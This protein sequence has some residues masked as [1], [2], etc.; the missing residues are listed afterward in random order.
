MKKLTI[1][2][3]L[4]ISN[5]CFSQ[6]LQ[7]TFDSEE[8]I[9]KNISLSESGNY[10]LI[11]SKN[12]IQLYK[13]FSKPVTYEPGSGSKLVDK[14]FFDFSWQTKMDWEL[15]HSIPI[16]TMNI[17]DIHLDELNK[18]IYI[19]DIGD[20]MVTKPPGKI[21]TY[22]Y[23][24]TE[25]NQTNTLEITHNST[26]GA[27]G[28]SFDL[29]KNNTYM[30]VNMSYSGKISLFKSN[31]NNWELIHEISKEEGFEFK[32]THIDINYEGSIF[33]VSKTNME[34]EV[35]YL[36]LYTIS[37]ETA[38]FSQ[39]LTD[40][41]PKT[42]YGL[43]YDFS[44]NGK[45]LSVGAREYLS[46]T[47]KTG[48]VY[49]YQFDDTQSKWIQRGDVLEGNDT[50]DQFGMNLKISGDGNKLFVTGTN[51]IYGAR[52][53][54]NV[55]EHTI[56]SFGES[57]WN[58]ISNMIMQSGYNGGYF[59]HQ[60][61]INNDGNIGAFSTKRN[62][63]SPPFLGSTDI[64]TFDNVEDFES[65]END[66]QLSESDNFENILY[67][68][69][70]INGEK[71]DYYDPY[72]N[73]KIVLSFTLDEKINNDKRY[74]WRI[75][76][77]NKESWSESN[78]FSL[79][80]IPPIVSLV[81]PIDGSK[82]VNGSNLTWDDIDEKSF[83][84]VQISRFNDFSDILI[85]DT[86]V[87][88]SYSI[89]SLNPNS[90]FWRIRSDFDGVKGEWSTIGYFLLMTDTDGDGIMDDV[91]IC[92]NT[93]TGET[94]DNN[95]CSDSQKDTDGD[96]IMDDVDI[97]PNTPTGETVD[98]DGCSDSQK[99][100]DGDGIMDDVDI[101]PNTPTGE[102]VDNNG[103]FYLPLDNFNIQVI[104][105]TCPDKKNGQII[106][107]PSNKN[108]N[109]TVSIDGNQYNFN[110]TETVLNLLPGT[111]DFCVSITGIDSFQ[112][113]Y[114][115]NI[116]EGVKISGKS[117][118]TSNKTSIEITQG[119]SPYSIFIN[120]KEQ[121]KTSSP[122][123]LVET[124]SGDLI[125]VK[126]SIE[127]EGVFSKSIDL[128]DK[129]IVYPNPTNGDFKI[130]LPVSQKEVSIELYTINSKL[131]SVKTYP[132]IYGE[133]QLSIEDK[134]LGIYIIKVLLDTP[135]YLKII[136]N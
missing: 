16:N 80:V 110:D 52:G 46:E 7:Y 135:V 94:V 50:Y 89:N 107:S 42:E 27:V 112:Q 56:S 133:I 12:S 26:L 14:L 47:R 136:K 44:D 32:N 54:V 8:S 1:F 132:V 61:D 18:T 37:N 129:M 68:K 55:Y 119:T 123:F 78:S 114:S 24:D 64:Y 90:Y 131:I 71:D 22:T 20:W 79:Y 87:S 67:Q 51:Q 82:I 28:L 30:I 3:F 111:Y 59:G 35:S 36:D 4:L 98:T 95:G 29:S 15:I 70:N 101:C 88:N 100:T 117:S 21:H 92:P 120:G 60:M 93:P 74:F 102:T 127:C 83:Y 11:Q 69:L 134:P 9:G 81:S 96:G 106:I 41:I 13:K 43:S 121:F 75:K 39:T 124:T 57:K 53:Y 108:Y 77:S 72:T 38:S 34:S 113:C 40:N 105:E 10:L 115:V 130:L 85:S 48:S 66:I 19:S 76:N 122:S 109:Y 49:N 25:I 99:D 125:E 5:Y 84:E 58:N 91:D 126:T 128:L 17:S 65:I 2:I 97:C 63:D 33:G 104:S 103:C 62:Y 73:G 31:Q 23:S 118:T 45:F 6:T 86:S 116:D